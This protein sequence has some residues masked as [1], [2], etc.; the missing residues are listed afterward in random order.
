MLGDMLVTCYEEK[1]MFRKLK[2]IK[3]TMWEKKKKKKEEE[4]EE[5][6]E[7]EDA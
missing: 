5:E 4:E 7:G 2:A 3:K 6:E 1:S